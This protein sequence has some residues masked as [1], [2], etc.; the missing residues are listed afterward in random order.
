MKLRDIHTVY[1]LGVGGIGM[2]ALARWFKANDFRVFGYDKTKTPLTET[3]SNEGI[4]IH[5]DDKL[6][7]MPQDV[8]ESNEGVLVVYTPAVPK[9]HFG[10]NLLQNN[11][12]ELMKRAQVL[13]AITEDYQTVGVAGT[14]GK[15]TTSSILAHILHDSKINCTA[16]LGG[17][18]KNYNSNLILGDPDEEAVMVVEADEFDR[19]FLTLSPDVAIVTSVDA[20]HLDIYG[21]GN[22]LITS[23][24]EYVS[25]LTPGGIL[26]VN[27]G[28]TENLIAGRDDINVITYGLQNAD[29]SVNNIRVVDGEQVFDYVSPEYSITDIQLSLPGFHN[30]Q[31]TVG[32]ITAA[33]KVGLGPK[34]V[35]A[36]VGSYCGVKRR[37]E[38]VIKTP[39]LVYIDDY[40]H[41]PTEI[42]AFVESV[43]ALYP[44]RK[45]TVLFQPHLF[46][47]T[48]D[49]MDDFANA[50]SKVDELIL[51]NVYPARELPIDGITSEVLLE[52]VTLSDKTLISD[53]NLMD[54]FAGCDLD[55][56]ATVGAGDIDR[57]VQPIQTLLEGRVY[58]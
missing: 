18:T 28:I 43:R 10:L 35:R 39:E 32:A 31:N 7:A 8:M 16:F 58:A 3:L 54:H 1:F 24:K 9:S 13:G 51:L 46:S 40:A 49:F 5:Y 52:K 21:D 50:L 20:D 11:G 2:S 23:F 17:I 57:F 56:I 29:V 30:I 42:N 14:H 38:Y 12:Y 47:R 37:F 15:T 55:I 4:E 45:L 22:A 25:R 26:I 6:S 48:R 34:Q 33:L 19:S 36:A 44:G 27:E 53:E 41:H